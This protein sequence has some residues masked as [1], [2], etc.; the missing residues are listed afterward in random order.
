MRIIVLSDTHRRF[1]HFYDIVKKHQ[2]DAQLLIHLGD[3]RRE[4]EE[5][6]DLFPELNLVCVRGNCDLGSM[7]P[8]TQVVA[9]ENVKILCTHGHNLSVKYTLEPLKKLAE[10]NDCR[11]ALYGHTHKSDTHYEGGIYFMNPGSPTEPRDYQPSY[12]IIDI[13]PQG[14]LPFIVKL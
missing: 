5:I 12:G 6:L 3:G 11:I 1:H 10:E 7:L 13:T 14:I 4:V 2:K 9:A 8:E